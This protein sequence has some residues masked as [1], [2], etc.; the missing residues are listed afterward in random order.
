VDAAPL[1][2][3]PCVPSA[4]G[5]P[6]VVLTVGKLDGV[7][8]GHRHLAAH[9]Q[10]EAAR[11]GARSAAVVLHPDPA[12]V[13]GG[14]PV[15]RLTTI[16]DRCGRLR[17][18]GVDIVEPLQFTAEVAALS[19]SAF[20]DRLAE[21][22]DIVGMVVGPDFAFGRN[23]AGNLV[24]LERLA[25]ARGFSLRVVPP[26]V[27]GGEWVSSRRVRARI[28]EGDIEV[29][30]TL[31]RQPPR[32][33][34]TVV[35][36][37]ARGRRLGYP[38]ANLDPTTDFAVPAN[39]IYAVRASWR[40]RAEAT[41]IRADGVASI[42]VR[43]TFDQAARLVEVHLLDFDGD[44]YGRDITV[45]F[46]A[47]QRSE[48]RFDS[49]P[50]LVTQMARDVALARAHHA[51]ESAAGWA[52]PRGATTGCVSGHDFAA[53]CTHAAEAVCAR[54]RVRD[55]DASLGRRQLTLRAPDDEALLDAWLQA[56]ED[57]G[58]GG[59]VPV[60]GTVYQ[61][62]AGTLNALVWTR[63]EADPSTTR[64]VRR[65]APIRCRAD[66]WLDTE[67]TVVPAPVA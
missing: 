65:T 38:T 27:L 47:R 35:H 54:D 8:A 31:L 30:R 5:R 44:L 51:R 23:R 33:I 4:S 63:G 28:E 29:A 19:P 3:S 60:R 67:L 57:T 58:A 53:L 10:A 56:L 24:D 37:A 49:V 2:E 25:A 55:A 17:T 36:G 7:H 50:A 59:A 6:R 9:T 13:L 16:E 48:L 18:F 46:L 64:C 1:T 62:G 32:L 52:A 41:P 39:G 11:L 15:A 61:A 21:R 14:L 34:G 45:D 12:A 66:G 43:P 40:E 20:L 26:L 42:G 22:F